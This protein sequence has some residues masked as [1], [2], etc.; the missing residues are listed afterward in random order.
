ML[1]KKRDRVLVSLVIVVVNSKQR[2]KGVW[3]GP[4][5]QTLSLL[6][7]RHTLRNPRRC[8]SVG[9]GFWRRKGRGTMKWGALELH[10]PARRFEDTMDA[11][12][13]GGG[14]ALDRWPQL[15]PP[16][17]DTSTETI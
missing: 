2:V 15:L 17:D 6:D 1:I 16:R 13:S 11:L 10:Q 4:G 7:V 5:G 9:Q 12:A 14:R 8:W 3:V